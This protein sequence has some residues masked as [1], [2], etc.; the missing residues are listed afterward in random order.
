MLGLATAK[1]H[2][3][4]KQRFEALEA[5]VI[6]LKNENVRLRNRL[7]ELEKQSLDPVPPVPKS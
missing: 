4:L 1:D 5:I 3:T 7:A 2:L 6:T